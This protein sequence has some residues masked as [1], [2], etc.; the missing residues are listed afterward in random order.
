MWKVQRAACISLPAGATVR[1]I[2]GLHKATEGF[3][4][5]TFPLPPCQ[6]QPCWHLGHFSICRPIPNHCTGCCWLSPHFPLQCFKALAGRSRKA[7][8]EKVRVAVDGFWIQNSLFLAALFFW[9]PPSP[10]FHHCESIV[11]MSK[12]IQAALSFVVRSLGCQN[13][14]V[15]SGFGNVHFLWVSCSVLIESGEKDKGFSQPCFLPAWFPKGAGIWFLANNGRMIGKGRRYAS[16]LAWSQ[17]RAENP[18]V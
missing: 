9:S 17:K 16:M 11:K 6:A 2:D 5:C 10:P 7:H 4:F 18:G 14:D 15:A 1:G 13:W 8:M 12:G 3:V